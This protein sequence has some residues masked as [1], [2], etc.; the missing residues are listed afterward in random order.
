MKAPV[1][2]MS[3]PTSEARLSTEVAGAL[4]IELAVATED[5]VVEALNSGGPDVVPYATEGTA[6]VLVTGLGVKL[7]VGRADS[8]V[9][10]W[11]CL[12]VLCQ[13]LDLVD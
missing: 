11:A 4:A 10:V 9:V 8:V 7:E 1:N 13:E 2:V 6:F 3:L 5:L 12:G